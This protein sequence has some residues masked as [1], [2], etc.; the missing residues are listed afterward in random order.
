MRAHLVA[1]V[2]IYVCALRRPAR[3]NIDLATDN[4]LTSSLH[5]T[6]VIKT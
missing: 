4:S 3:K 6:Y 2:N 5:Q 1:K